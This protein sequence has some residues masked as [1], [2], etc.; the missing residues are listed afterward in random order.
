M[1]SPTGLLRARDPA[2]GRVAFL[3]LFYDLVFV[4]AITQLSHFLLHHYM[5]R[6]AVESGLLF[7]AI[8]WVWIFTTW[9]LNW[10]DPQ[11][12]PVRVMVYASMLLGLF[13][14]MSVERAF[15]DRGLAFALAFVAMQ[16]GRS[17][18]TAWCFAGHQAQHR[19][20]LRISAWFAAS[21]VFWIAGALAGHDAR[22]A[23]W[24]LALAIEYLGP[25][26][27]FRTPG[28]G[29][30][31]T[32][33]WD[34]RG[35][36]MAERCGLFV[37]ICLG[38]TLLINGATFAAS[39][40]TAEGTTAFVVNFLGTVAMWW[41]YFHIGQTRAAHLAEHTDDPGRFARIAYTYAHIPIVAGIVL[42]AIGAELV[43]A[44]P[45]G[46]ATAGEAAAIVG[47]VAL[48]LVGNGWFKGLTARSATLSHLIG[49]GLCLVVAI[50]H[51]W[52]SPLVLGT[53]ALSILVAVAVLEHASLGGMRG[54]A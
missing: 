14:S 23:I 40:W 35:E 16:L 2:A 9:A 21:G 31:A 33:E 17:L 53:L 5:L 12:G 42:A 49:L 19:G 13:M 27:R 41:L 48:F 46:Q 51:P 44:H 3:E 8:W 22:L 54:V 24:G 39:D 32:S 7:L 6:G 52:L 18:F 30:S 10:L 1:G 28:L 37:I 34:V 43:L 47:G 26:L 20:Y 15:D 4:F 36:H 45:S 38:E 50:L 29:T 11:R 25:W